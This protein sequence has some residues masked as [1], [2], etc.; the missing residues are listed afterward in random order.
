M[1]NR[2]GLIPAKLRRRSPATALAA[3]LFPSS[4]SLREMNAL[5]VTRSSPASRSTSNRSLATLTALYRVAWSQLRSCSVI[6][7]CLLRSKADVR[8][9]GSYV[10]FV[11][12]V[13]KNVIL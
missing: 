1:H 12:R 7:E 9:E 8:A 2:A 13:C 11:P 4:P 6:A 5:P 10:R 3:R